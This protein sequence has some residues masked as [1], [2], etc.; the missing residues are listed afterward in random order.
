MSDRLPAWV[1]DH[2]EVW[3]SPY[4][5][6]G[7]PCVRGTRV[8]VDVV[9]DMIADGETAA[10]IRDLWPDVTYPSIWALEEALEKKGDHRE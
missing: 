8:P 2:P 7:T 1:Y 3:A 10:E 5:L 4:R 6:G 9:L